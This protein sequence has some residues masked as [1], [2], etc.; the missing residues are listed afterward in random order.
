MYTKVVVDVDVSGYV[1]EGGGLRVTGITS[2]SLRRI[3]SILPST[4]N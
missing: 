4:K 2:D 3:S 1:G